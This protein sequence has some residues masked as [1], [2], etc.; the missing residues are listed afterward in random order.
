MKKYH[1]VLLSIKWKEHE[2]YKIE[3]E[4]KEEL[5]KVKNKENKWCS[6]I[7]LTVLAAQKDQIN[8]HNLNMVDKSGGHGR[9]PRRGLREKKCINMYKNV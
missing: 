2:L 8:T 1:L 7:F 9:M 4:D 6:V 5:V 3:V